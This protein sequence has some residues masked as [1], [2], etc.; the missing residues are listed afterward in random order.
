MNAQNNGI[1]ANSL[2]RT[3]NASNDHVMETVQMSAGHA[4]SASS[5]KVEPAATLT[6]R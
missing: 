1:V 5:A 6:L 2:G 4:F 3:V